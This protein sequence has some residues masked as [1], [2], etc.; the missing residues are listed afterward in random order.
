M[1]DKKKIKEKIDSALDWLDLL[2]SEIPVYE[3]D[4]RLTPAEE[5]ISKLRGDL[6]D[7]LKLLDEE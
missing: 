6:E 3:N 7:V 5:T 2:S 4:S 1:S